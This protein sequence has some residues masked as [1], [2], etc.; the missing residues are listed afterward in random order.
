MDFDV[1]KELF[2]FKS[3]KIFDLDIICRVCNEVG[4]N[5]MHN[6]FPRPI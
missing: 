2:A 4:F 1:S 3:K 6:N 5:I